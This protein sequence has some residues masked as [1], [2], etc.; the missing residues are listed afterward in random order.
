MSQEAM[1][2]LRNLT[3]NFGGLVAVNNLSFKLNKGEFL[4]FIGP[5]GAGKTVTINMISGL[6]RPTNG[7]IVYNG[8]DITGLR[9]DKLVAKGISRTVQ[10][11]TLFFELPVIG[12]IML[13]VPQSRNVGLV[14]AIFNTTSNRRKEEAIEKKA[15]R[16][17]D[18]LELTHLKDALPR[19]LPYGTQ[20]E[21]AIGI[22][23]AADSNLILF[24]EPLTGLNTSEVLKVMDKILKVHDEGHTILL[25]EHNMQAVMNYSEKVVVIDFGSKIAEGTPEEVQKNPEVIKAYLGE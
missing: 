7:S 25:V 12:N 13:A 1:L 23:L 8:E 21:V 4:G 14:E 17:L 24:D 19:D 18:F 20:K 10:L 3:K 5:N 11:S 22:A 15:L 16:V 2:E 6:T 9:P